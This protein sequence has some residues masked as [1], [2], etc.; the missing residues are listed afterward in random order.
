MD[1]AVFFP[2]YI[3]KLVFVEVDWY[4]YYPQGTILFS[5]QQLHIKNTNCEN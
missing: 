3:S 5:W 2:Y 4:E 1:F